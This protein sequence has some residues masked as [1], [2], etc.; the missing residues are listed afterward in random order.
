MRAKFEV[1]VDRKVGSFSSV[2]VKRSS[3]GGV[4]VPKRYLADITEIFYMSPFQRSTT[5]PANY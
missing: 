3:T 4:S 1:R 2:Q 5:P